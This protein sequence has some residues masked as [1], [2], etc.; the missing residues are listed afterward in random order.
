M[1]GDRHTHHVTCQLLSLEA[2]RLSFQK[3]KKS[4]SIESFSG[5]KANGAL[6]CRALLCAGGCW[7]APPLWLLQWHR[8]ARAAWRI[9]VGDAPTPHPPPPPTP[10]HHHQA[11]S[12]SFPHWRLNTLRVSKFWSL[13]SPQCPQEKG[14]TPARATQYPSVL[15]ISL[16]FP[17]SLQ[18]LITAPS[19]WHFVPLAYSTGEI[20]A[21]QRLA[22]S[23]CTTLADLCPVE[24]KKINT[25]FTTT[26]TLASLK[27]SSSL[28]RYAEEKK[29]EKA[30]HN[31]NDVR[32]DV[33]G[34]THVALPPLFTLLCVF[35]RVVEAV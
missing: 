11:A 8:Q 13:K 4:K 24:E 1:A 5:R 6:V 3:K 19:V 20:V 10:H 15:L 17:A 32:A 16:F 30:Y 21:L 23:F 14:R 22:S 35:A 31:H 34:N 25:K 2:G 27:I 12:W 26:A 29:K 9:G 28:L 33:G 18:C 7:Q